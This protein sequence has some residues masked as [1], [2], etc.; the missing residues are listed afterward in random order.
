MKNGRGRRILLSIAVD[1]LR[2]GERKGL[3]AHVSDRRRALNIL[4]SHGPRTGAPA[5][6]AV[7]HESG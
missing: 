3:V 6:V 2:W 4:N 7:G 5:V 1:C